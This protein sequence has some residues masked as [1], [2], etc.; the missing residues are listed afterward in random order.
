MSTEAHA[1]RLADVTRRAAEMKMTLHDPV[2]DP[3]KGTFIAEA[4]VRAERLESATKGT[5][6]EACGKGAA[7]VQGV[8]SNALRGFCSQRGFMPSDEVLASAHAGMENLIKVTGEGKAVGGLVL[9]SA[10]DSTDGLLIRD[11]MVALVLPVMLQSIT[12][13]MCSL[14]PG[15]FNSSEIF[16]VYRVASDTFGDL[17]AGDRL[18][19][20]YTGQYS[21]MDQRHETGTGD[22]AKTGSSSEFIISSVVKF[23]KVYP[24]KKKSIKIMHDRNVVAK[25]DGS[26]N[27]AG[28]FKVGATTINVTG[29]VNYATGVVDPVFSTAPANGIKIHVGFDVDI[30]KDPSLIPAVN[31]EMDSKTLYPHEA[32]I[33][34]TTT[35][36]ALWGLRR[37]YNLN[38]DSMAM[39]AMRNLLA[40]DKDRKHLRDLYFYAKG[41]T[42][43]VYTIP[44]SGVS[45][46]DYF[47]TLLVKLLE[48]DNLLLSQTQ[49]SGLVG[50]VADSKSCAIF[51]AMGPKIQMVPG[52]RPVPQPH[53]V[54]RIFGM[55]DLYEDPQ[56]TNYTSLCYAKGSGLG[57]SGYIAGDAIPAMQFK[58]AM[59][60]DLKYNNTLWELAYRD[61][62]PF[63][64][65]EYLTTLKL[66]AS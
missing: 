20:A 1:Q 17:T 63:D 44:S 64:G 27:L 65:R 54:G 29:T 31:H 61:V 41:E 48:I 16:K 39:L 22:A 19:Q 23:G 34:A 59:Q 55:Y 35:L 13:Q 60:S 2:V 4:A 62:Q 58:H 45:Q 57:E 14:I 9:E 40:A 66:T 8:A 33:S 10:I 51:K 37:E 30:E 50:I 5:I 25:D 21:S 32:A 18:N 6:F 12:T 46:D 47:A 52:Y 42:S 38:A 53:Y 49:T 3:D 11:R 28:T 43:W 15:Q 24:F 26:G 56:G 7:T 36:Q